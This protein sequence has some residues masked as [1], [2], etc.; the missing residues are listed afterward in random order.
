M[1]YSQSDHDRAVELGGVGMVVTV[2]LVV[3]V[4]VGALLWS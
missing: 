4:L 3:A 1:P 2:I